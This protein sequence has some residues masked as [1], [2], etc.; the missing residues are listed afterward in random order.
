MV[1]MKK[2]AVQLPGEYYFT[3]DILPAAL[4]Q[5]HGNSLSHTHNYTGIPHWHDFSELVI[6]MAGSGTQNIDG[7]SRPVSAGDVFV[8][9][10]KTT[11]YFE[12]YKNLEITNI[13]FSEQLFS[14]L[15]NYLNRIPGYQLVFRIEPGLQLRRTF[16]NSLHLSPQ[17]LSHVSRLCEQIRSEQ[18]RHPS[19]YEAAVIS[20]LLN[21]I[22]FLS[23]AADKQKD[24][25]PAE[26][27]LASLFSTLEADFRE[28]WPL[29]RMA[30]C[31]GMS[32][33]TLLR[34][35]RIVLRKSPL[36]YLM[37][38]RLSSAAYLLRNTDRTVSEIAYACG[39]HD[40]NYFTKS[41]QTHF[42]QTPTRYRK[43]R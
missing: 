12:N 27:R 40:S 1:I 11:H 6:I 20:E 30:S 7:K 4:K 25:A 33:S 17:Q 35:F 41:F 34:T 16:H 23:R 31:A 14:G 2:N 10:G 9:A 13:M 36:Q 18:E 3:R 37:E 21:L 26:T 43:Q 24:T 28:D 15:G 5:V 22:I 38:L 29:Q 19:G 39:F 8:I 42:H 32:V